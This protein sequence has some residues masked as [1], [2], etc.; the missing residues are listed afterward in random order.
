[1]DNKETITCKGCG[2][3]TWYSTLDPWKT[4]TRF[5]QAGRTLRHR[6]T[7]AEAGAHIIIPPTEGEMELKTNGNNIRR[8]NDGD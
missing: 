7:C 8:D 6:C 4:S 2:A 3:S 5:V 1:M